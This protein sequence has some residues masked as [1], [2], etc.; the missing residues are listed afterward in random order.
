MPHLLH[1]VRIKPFDAKAIPWNEAWLPAR[2]S[3]LGFLN[4]ELRS[5]PCFYLRPKCS[6]EAGM[7]LISEYSSS[8]SSSDKKVTQPF[9]RVNFRKENFFRTS[10]G[11]RVRQLTSYYYPCILQ[12]LRWREIA[13]PHWTLNHHSHLS[14][15]KD[16]CRGLDESRMC[17]FF[18]SIR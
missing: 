4:R 18:Y 5:E 1:A 14:C 10:D 11:P 16:F 6:L 17:H 8:F 12:H 15:L 13:T 2:N 3:A 7:A 9:W